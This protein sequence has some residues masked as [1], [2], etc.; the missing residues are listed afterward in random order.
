MLETEYEKGIRLFSH[1]GGEEPLCGGVEK[2]DN[3]PPQFKYHRLFQE[4]GKRRRHPLPDAYRFVS[5]GLRPVQTQ[6]DYAVE[7][8]EALVGFFLHF[9]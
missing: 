9:S 6:T 1:E 4:H 2:A 5:H 3:H 8:V 7:I